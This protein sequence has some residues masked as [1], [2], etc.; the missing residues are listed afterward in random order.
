MTKRERNFAL[1]GF[2]FGQ[3]VAW[4]IVLAMLA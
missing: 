1:A 3:F 4:C 2:V